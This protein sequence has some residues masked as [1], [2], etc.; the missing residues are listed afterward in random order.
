[1]TGKVVERNAVRGII[2]V[3]TDAGDYSVIEVLGADQINVG[4]TVGWIG[5]TPLGRKWL[6]NMSKGVRCSAFFQ[7]HGVHAKNLRQELFL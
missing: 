6:I 7:S 3:Q 5:E 4:D 2:G 1:M